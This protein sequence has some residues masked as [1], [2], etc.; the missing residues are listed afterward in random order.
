MSRFV[1]EAWRRVERPEHLLSPSMWHPISVTVVRQEP[2]LARHSRRFLIPATGTNAAI[3]GVT[4]DP[5]VA[6]RPG[7]RVM[8][9][10]SKDN[11][12]C[13]TLP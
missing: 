12:A 1:T 9:F 8:K 5:V 10:R 7:E 4:I 11:A 3:A 13:D 2:A 6:I